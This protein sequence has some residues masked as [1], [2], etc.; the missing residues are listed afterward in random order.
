MRGDPF[1][2]QKKLPVFPHSK[3][4]QQC[5]HHLADD[6]PCQVPMDTEYGDAEEHEA[7]PYQQAGHTVEKGKPGLAKPV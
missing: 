6:Q 2:Q 3:H 7:K 4:T 5:L 1:L